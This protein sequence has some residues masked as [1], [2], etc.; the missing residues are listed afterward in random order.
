MTEEQIEKIA[1]KP[2]ERNRGTKSKPAK[3]RHLQKQMKTWIS[4]KMKMRNP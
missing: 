1:E 2:K 3:I 4:A